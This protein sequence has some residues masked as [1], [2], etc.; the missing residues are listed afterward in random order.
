MKS[1]QKTYALEAVVAGYLGVDIAPGFPLRRT[2]VAAAELFRPGKLVETEGLS[3]SLGGVVANT[4][5]AMRRFGKRVE[6]MGCVGSDALGDMVVSQLREQGVTSGIRRDRRRGTAYGIVVAPPGMDRIFFE[7]PGCNAVFTGDHIDYK[8]VARSR[9]FHFGYPPLMKRL[10]VNSGT[11]LRKMFQ[12]VRKL[13]VATSLDLALPDSDSPAGKANWRRILT[14]TLPHVDIFVPSIE[15]ILFML[16]PEQYARALASAPGCDMV[17]AIPQAAFEHLA[18]QIL[19]L[20]VTVLMIKAGHRGAYLRTGN[21][22][23]LGSSTTLK[24]S[25][26]AWS[27]RSHWASSLPVDSRRF[28]NACGAGDCAV[29]GLLAA[30]LNGVDLERAA[31]YAMLAGRDNLYGVD[32]CSGLSDWGQMTRYVEQQSRLA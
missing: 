4:G 5:L 6:L 18:D 17:D 27:H 21:V 20:G 3:F 13:G 14:A 25:P 29:A 2:S 23:K 9:L 10:W 8:A 32:A 19:A 7:D 30:M 26:N 1:S 15:E 22:A 28:K 11:E 12:R 24:L 31:R 16:E